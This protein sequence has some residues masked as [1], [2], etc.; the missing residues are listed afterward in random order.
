MS[1]QTKINFTAP[2]PG[3]LFKYGSQQYQIYE[4]LIA[5]G[6]T[7]TEIQKIGCMSHTKRVSEIRKKLEPYLIDVKAER[8]HGGVYLYK[9]KGIN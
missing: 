7:N 4:K 5:G 8:Q 6:A 2:M 9:L 1:Q 3:E